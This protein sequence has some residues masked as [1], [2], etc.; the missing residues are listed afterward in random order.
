MSFRENHTQSCTLLKL[1]HDNSFPKIA[2]VDEDLRDNSSKL[3]PGTLL[4]LLRPCQDEVTGKDALRAATFDAST[5]EF[6]LVLEDMLMVFHRQYH[7]VAKRMNQSLGPSMDVGTLAKLTLPGFPVFAVS[8]DDQDRE[9]ERILIHHERETVRG[10]L[11][12]GQSGWL[13]IPT[14][15]QGIFTPVTSF[16]NVSTIL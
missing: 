1:M 3:K 2:E 6:P 16:N 11:A 12:K 4:W 5:V 14:E 13:V 7:E 10:Y 8:S 9:E 15:F